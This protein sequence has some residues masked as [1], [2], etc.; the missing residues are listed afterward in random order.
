M[1]VHGNTLGWFRVKIARGATGKCVE[2]ALCSSYWHM[3][4][5]FSKCGSQTTTSG[6]NTLDLIWNANTCDLFIQKFWMWDPMIMYF[7]RRPK[8]ENHCS[9]LSDRLKRD[10][11]SLIFVQTTYHCP[12]KLSHL[13]T[14]NSISYFPLLRQW[15]NWEQEMGFIWFVFIILLANQTIF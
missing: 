2:N 3:N 6:R 7:W 10:T 5:W 11:N 4:H 8:S 15:D 9:R 12:Y 13:S 1:T 14:C